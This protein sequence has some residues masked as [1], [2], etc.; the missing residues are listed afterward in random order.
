M[1]NSKIKEAIVTIEKIMNGP[2]GTVAMK[3]KLE[4]VLTLLQAH[5][6][7]TPDYIQ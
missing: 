7:Q 2:H 5:L 6:P 4:N 1:E 3:K